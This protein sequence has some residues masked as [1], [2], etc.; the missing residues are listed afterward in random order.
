[1]TD[2]KNQ[3]LARV[4]I[5]SANPQN[6]PLKALRQRQSHGWPL[7]SLNE[8]KIAAYDVRGDRKRLVIGEMP[9]RHNAR[10]GFKSESQNLMQ[11][12]S[13]SKEIA[14]EPL[15]KIKKGPGW[16]PWL[17]LRRTATWGIFQ[18]GV[19]SSATSAGTAFGPSKIWAMTSVE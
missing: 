16:T 9:I 19:S 15:S 8:R 11:T 4:G 12:D 14:F 10:T 2:K 1:M 7:L 17:S 13:L 5:A 6:Y 18:K 3:M